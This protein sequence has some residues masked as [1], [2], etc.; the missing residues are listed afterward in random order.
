MPYLP[1][2]PGKKIARKNST[3]KSL[4][5]FLSYLQERYLTHVPWQ[6]LLIILISL[7]STGQIMR[8]Y[9][10]YDDLAFFY[11]FQFEDA[12][13]IFQLPAHA[14]HGALQ[15]LFA[16][17]FALFGYLPLGYYIISWLSFVLVNL[18][19]WL[20]MRLW[21]P[22][23]PWLAF[24]A[25][26]VAA[27][28]YIGVG[29]FTFN[30]AAGFDVMVFLLLSLVCLIG[31]IIW[32]KA[33]SLALLLLLLASFYLAITYFQFRSYVLLAWIPLFVIA[34]QLQDATMKWRQFLL[35]GGLVLAGVVLF[36]QNASAYPQRIA[37]LQIDPGNFLSLYL[38]NLANL[39]IP[40]DIIAG[41][42]QIHFGQLALSDPDLIGADVTLRLVIGISLLILLVSLPIKLFAARNQLTPAAFFF[43]GS[44]LG[45]LALVVVAQSFTGWAPDVWD[46]THR[47][48]IIFLLPVAGLVGV[49]LALLAKYQRL[50]AIGLTLL[51]VVV[52]IVF[53]NI[54]IWQQYDSHGQHLAYFFTTIKQSLPTLDRNTV[55][56]INQNGSPR[57][58]NPFVT[59]GGDIPGTSYLAGL[60]GLNVKDL[61]LAESPLEAIQLAV[62]HKLPLERIYTLDYKRQDLADETDQFR[63]IVQT[64]KVI[65][66][67]HGLLNNEV[68]DL[69]L[70]MAAPIFLRLQLTSRLTTKLSLSQTAPKTISNEEVNRYFSLLLNEYR[71]R[72][73]MLAATSQ[74]PDAPDHGVGNVIDGRND[75]VW[76]PGQWSSQGASLT[77]DLGISQSVAQIVWASSRTGPWQLRAPVDYEIALSQDNRTFSPVKAVTGAPMLKTGQFYSDQFTPT[78]ARYVKLTIAKTAGGWTPAVDEIEVFDKT[79]TERELALY[80]A[81]KEQPQNYFVNQ[82]QVTAYLHEILQD[83]IP[84]DIAWR[85]DGD[86]G[87]PA[88]QTTRLLVEAN[89]QEQTYR[90]FIPKTGRILKSIKIV[91]SFS[92]AALDISHI[93]AWYPS[94]ANFT[95]DP[96][97]LVEENVH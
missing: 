64:G 56:S 15:F 46:S 25:A 6:V 1:I 26:V 93:E 78:I 34:L 51:I 71:R 65:S 70:S 28:S 44:L 63:Q 79:Y 49:L 69:K 16:P 45:G 10:S 40:S 87:Y 2:M 75:T 72:T 12:G 20:L 19:S 38:Q 31:L 13:R 77:I 61:L 82:N 4:H 62:K 73:L 66:L 74:T 76:I 43:S 60:Y 3:S 23:R 91:S 39:F 95:R 48:F 89:N 84:V 57:P 7:A 30:M 83:K 59:V 97:L 9:F 90:V 67:D 80:F 85:V 24:I 21:F 47:Y 8:L 36:W 32:R 55:L 92:P 86:G 22:S 35:A 96:D 41:V 5:G 88:G 33:A 50:I 52:H 27:S 11:G 37:F 53:S 29:A 68:K 18:A 14:P 42:G 58:V 94:L 81:I 17:Q 54:A